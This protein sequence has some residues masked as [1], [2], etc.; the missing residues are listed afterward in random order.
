MTIVVDDDRL[1]NK[2]ETSL[3]DDATVVNSTGHRFINN[4]FLVINLNITTI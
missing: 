4:L 3:T 2:F 1:V